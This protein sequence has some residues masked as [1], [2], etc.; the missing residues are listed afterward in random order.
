MIIPGKLIPKLKLPMIYQNI[1]EFLTI[2][3]Y[4][5]IFIK[6]NYKAPGFNI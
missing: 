6:T 1:S 3:N 2:Y 5:K 4:I